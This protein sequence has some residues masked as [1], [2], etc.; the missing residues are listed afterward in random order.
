MTTVAV[1]AAYGND[2]DG[3]SDDDGGGFEDVVVDDWG[4]DYHRLEMVA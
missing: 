4:C 3:E 2:S 1:A